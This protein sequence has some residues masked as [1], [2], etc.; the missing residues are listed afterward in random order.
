MCVCCVRMVLLKS[1]VQNQTEKR[2][3]S[4][5]IKWSLFKENVGS[6][7]IW[8]LGTNAQRFERNVI[9]TVVKKEGGD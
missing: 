2:K 6:G 5:M 7:S 1:W 8:T 9:P 4:F 3:K